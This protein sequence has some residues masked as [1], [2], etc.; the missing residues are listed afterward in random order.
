MLHSPSL[1][2]FPLRNENYNPNIFPS[3]SKICSYNIDNFGNINYSYSKNVENKKSSFSS[4]TT[5][6][7]LFKK[8]KPSIAHLLVE[9]LD[10]PNY[11]NP[12]YISPEKKDQYQRN[13][14]KVTRGLQRYHS[15]EHFNTLNFPKIILDEKQKN[16]LPIYDKG[17]E[18]IHCNTNYIAQ[19]SFK[20]NAPKFPITQ[21]FRKNLFPKKTLNQ[22][23]ENK[24]NYYNNNNTEIYSGQNASNNYTGNNISLNTN[25]NSLTNG[26]TSLNNGL[27]NYNA[28]GEEEPKFNF[29][30]SEFTI[31]KKIGEGA[32]GS[33]FT[34]KWKKNNKTYVLK[35]SEVIFEQITKKKKEV[36]KLLKDFVEI[37]G[38][39]GVIKIYGNLVVNNEFGTQYFYELMELGGKT[40]EKEIEIRE[41]KKLY[42][43]EYELMDIFTHLIKT[44]SALQTNH[45]THRDIN[46]TNIIMVNGKLKICDFGNSKVLKKDGFI[47]QKIRGS[48][49]FMSPILFKGL[50]SNDQSIRHNAYK[51]DVF[52]LGMC[53]FLAASLT[54]NGL[55]TIREIYNM[56]IIRKVLNKY[57]G[58]RYSLNLIDLLLSM[59]EID[60]NKRPDFT[61]LELL[62]PCL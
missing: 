31:L 19:T 27:N 4:L 37:T 43:Y 3:S 54:Y 17:N 59:L 22:Y 53:F 28:Y 49:L 33:I 5:N 44:F 7:F 42:Y 14:T 35:K 16:K 30:L 46:P 60:E 25:I 62:L 26:D 41:K 38:S 56:N 58:K 36:N 1:Q 45:F 12:S 11:N 48:E 29:K 8:S 10:K 39:D 15:T 61:Q 21:I 55:N 32:E 57:L 50:H 40:W 24:N 18:I 52:S 34:V 9:N 51:S 23:D 6:N 20:T 13:P 47:I 2:L